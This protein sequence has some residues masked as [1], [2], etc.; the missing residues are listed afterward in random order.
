[1]R[2]VVVVSGV[3][4]PV[5]AFGG[6]LK[7]VS[8]I[9]LGA[10]VIKETLKKAGL[11][12]VV[13]DE[14]AGFAPDKLKDKGI[15]ELEKKYHDYA[16]SLKPIAVDEVIIGN[17]VQAGQGQ[18]PARQ[19]MIRA[20]VPKETPAY[21]INKVC[22]SGL[23]SV[24][25]GA[26]SIASGQADVVIA[27]GME[28]M[29]NIPFAM[30]QAR[31]GYRMALTGIGEVHDLMV[32]DGLYEI[33]YGYH[34][35]I[36]AENIVDL[37]G[38]SRQEQDELSL[39]SHQRA[40]A[41]MTDGTFADEIIPVVLKGRKGDTIIDTDERPMDTS[42]EKLGKMKP[43]FKKDGSVTAGNASGIND[44]AASVLLMSA[45]KAKEY[46]LEPYIKI[47]GFASGGVDPAYMG[48]GPV[49]AVRKLLKANNM[50]VKDI[51]CWELNEAFAA[52]AIG[53]LRELGLPNDKPNE[54]GSGI[55]LGHPIGCTGARQLVTGMRQMKR[56][57]HKTGI[58]S[59]C[60]GGGMGF[61]MLVER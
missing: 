51:D 60:I 49:P 23:K 19:A 11:R 5:G 59:M 50:T 36:T 12:P 58:I 10:L 15:T 54:L 22:S 32:F 40:R 55:S 47:K 26:A 29:S 31:W 39:L 28:S 25:I 7:D 2:E 8:A 52:Q 3:R 13:S 38:I 16:D 18:N 43:A 30:L 21:T 9:D 27:G 1:M 56:K 17:V 14:A 20:G 61:A 34:M 53:C 24:A 42:M 37:Y 35:G 46:G 48:L 45:D 6:S 44:G 33:F 41:A 57:G 4:T